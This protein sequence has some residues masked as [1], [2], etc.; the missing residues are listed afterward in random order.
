[1]FSKTAR[2]FVLTIIISSGYSFVSADEGM[3]LLNNLPFAHLRQNYGFVPTPEWVEHVQK[4]SAR[5]P[6][7]SASF[8]SKDGLI[9]T[10]G[11]CAEDAVMALSTPAVNLYKNGFYA[12]TLAKE[13]KTGLNIRVLMNI[14]PKGVNTPGLNCENVVLYHGGLEQSYCY[15]IYNDIRLVFSSEKNTWLF[16]GDADNFEFP[17]YA[18][19]AAFLRAYENNKPASTPFHFKWSRGGAS[20]RELIF[21]SG[22]PGRTQRLLTSSA[23]ATERDVRAPFVLDLAR[24][25]ELTTQQFML[26]GREQRRLAESDLFSWQNT[27]KLYAGKVLGLQDDKLIHD[28]EF[29]QTA[30]FTMVNANNPELGKQLKEGW[31]LVEDAQE[32]QRALYPKVMLYVRG[33]GF[34]SRLYDYAASLVSGNVQLAKSVLE[35]RA[36]EAPLNLEYEEAKLRDSL[37]YMMEVMK[38]YDPNMRA[39]LKFGS[40]PAEIAHRLVS[41]TQL[42]DIDWHRQAVALGQ[43]VISGSDDPM[44][45]LAGI[46]YRSSNAYVEKLKLALNLEKQ[47]YAK[48]SDVMFKHFGTTQYPDATFTLRLSFG[49]V[50]GYLNG[51][52]DRR[53]GPFTTIGGAYTRSAEF[54]NQGDFKLPDRWV[55]RKAQVNLRTPF[56]FISNL[57][58]TG[59]NSGSPVFNKDREI[60]GLVFDGNAHSLVSDYDYNYSAKSRAVAVHSAGI[61]E[62]LSK[63]YRADRLVR[64]LTQR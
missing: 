51:N 53:I 22:H 12:P 8:V 47:G 2:V 45:V 44:L 21:V 37:S 16:G 61:L 19:D 20:E 23:L 1:M 49:T 50:A 27:R 46:V 39:L 14:N 64:E 5:L 48:I 17:R 56:N 6:N 11:H 40:G 30:T 34:D 29:K 36:S 13:L 9:M 54:G 52:A 15:K 32:V 7:C 10:N 3:W 4:S 35:A 41:E 38:V 55:T 33:L 58:I 42:E 63:I 31:Q 59:G 26:K 43:N 28:K 57:D 60:V 18:L 24:R 25:R 62:I